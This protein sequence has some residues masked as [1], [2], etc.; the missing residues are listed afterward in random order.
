M[1]VSLY[2]KGYMLPTDWLKKSVEMLS[3]ENKCMDAIYLNAVI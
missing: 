1:P 2:E 3:R